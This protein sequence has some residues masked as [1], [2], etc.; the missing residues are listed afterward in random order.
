MCRNTTVT[1]ELTGTTIMTTMEQKEETTSIV[2]SF[3][4]QQKQ[5]ERKGQSEIYPVTEGLQSPQTAAKYKMNFAHFL[6]Y[7]KIP[8][9]QGIFRKLKS[10]IYT[11][12][13]SMLGL[14]TD[15]IHS[16][17]QNAVRQSMIIWLIERGTKR[18]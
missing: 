15:T 12:F 4:G 1:I 11:R 10:S 16:Q 5:K 17:R 9:L 2:T 13:R 6:D 3:E 14:V 7:I 18:N 8:D